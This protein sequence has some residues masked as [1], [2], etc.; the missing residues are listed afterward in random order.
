MLGWPSINYLESSYN[1]LHINKNGFIAFDNFNQ[2]IFDPYSRPEKNK[3]SNLK[4]PSIVGLLN[5][6]ELGGPVN[7]EYM[8]FTGQPKQATL[9]GRVLIDTC[10][11]VDCTNLLASLEEPVEEESDSEISPDQRTF[12][13][14][15]RTS[16]IRYGIVAGYYKLP[17]KVFHDSLTTSMNREVN[18]VPLATFQI[19]ILSKT[20]SSTDVHFRY[21]SSISYKSYD[22]I[23][24]NAEVSPDC[25]LDPLVIY[26]FGPALDSGDG[27]SVLEFYKRDQ[28]YLYNIRERLRVDSH[29]VETFVDSRND[30]VWNSDEC[31][32]VPC[33]SG[34]CYD[35]VDSYYCECPST[36]AGAN[37]E[38]DYD[39]CGDPTVNIG[40]QNGN[41]THV[42][43]Q[44]YSCA[45]EERWTG[46]FCDTPMVPC[47]SFPCENSSQ[48]ID[49]IVS[50]DYQ[51]E[52]QLTYVG[53]NC[54]R[55]ENICDTIELP[56][57]NFG[58]CTATDEF[59][60]TYNC[61]C[62]DG[63]RGDLCDLIDDCASQP[64]LH[65]ATCAHGNNYVGFKCFCEA[66]GNI[67]K[68]IF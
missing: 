57:G 14:Q 15:S 30:Q 26:S 58:N 13:K 17:T 32:S 33:N 36:K 59:A 37:C 6:F 8:D 23:N 42:D 25:G 28:N 2:R 51:C 31:I 16:D 39:I 34:V 47:D 3:I 56:C 65:N 11:G 66:V 10:S 43:L 4:L 27:N 61:E 53:K 41:C 19:I 38:K 5:E 21:D 40:C 18:L 45:C 29:S 52:C 67:L 64:C 68:K 12:L 60:T 1:T 35:R 22:H 20:D 62:V 24:C 46:R 7:F 49:D 63:Y 44:T 54:Q 9:N 48:C 55:K 50:Y